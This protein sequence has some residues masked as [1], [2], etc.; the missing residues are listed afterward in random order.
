LAKIGGISEVPARSVWVRTWTYFAV[1]VGPVPAIAGQSQGPAG[2][3]GEQAARP[4]AVPQTWVTVAVP[5]LALPLARA[6]AVPMAVPAPL[7]EAALA[8]SMAT[9]RAAA[10][11]PFCSWRRSAYN[12]PASMTMVAKP[13]SMTMQMATMTAITPCSLVS[14]PPVTRR[15]RLSRRI[16][17]Q[18]CPG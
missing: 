2:A 11:E 7:Q 17:S 15:G 16:A 13:S 3:A 18:P 8:Q 5:S 1:A 10:S 6:A 9:A 14:A 12:E 4:G